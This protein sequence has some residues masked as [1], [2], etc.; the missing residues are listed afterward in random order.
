MTVEIKTMRVVEE[1]IED[2]MEAISTDGESVVIYWDE[3]DY[4]IINYVET[5]YPNSTDLPKLKEINKLFQDGKI[6]MV[7]FSY[8]Y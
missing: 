2:S 4:D 8:A 7:V 5:N 6:D 3:I 1:T